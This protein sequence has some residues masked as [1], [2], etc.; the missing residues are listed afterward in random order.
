MAIFVRPAFIFH[1][2]CCCFGTLDLICCAPTLA[3]AR[4]DGYLDVGEV[5][6]RPLT[7]LSSLVVGQLAN[8]ILL[9]SLDF[10]LIGLFFLKID[11]PTLYRRH[12]TIYCVFL[13]IIDWLICSFVGCRWL[14]IFN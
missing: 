9:V 2:S 14:Y 6:K 4:R 8:E 13:T 12:R 5:N 7:L 3:Q 10:L 11:C 1:L